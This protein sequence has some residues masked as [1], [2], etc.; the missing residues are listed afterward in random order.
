M[1]DDIPIVIWVQTYPYC[2]PREIEA[3]LQRWLQIHFA[4]EG[5]RPLHSFTGRMIRMGFVDIRI[6]NRLDRIIFMATS[7]T[8]FN[9]SLLAASTGT[10]IYYLSGYDHNFIYGY[11]FYT[12]Y[13][14]LVLRLQHRRLHASSSILP[15]LRCETRAPCI[16]NRFDLDDANRQHLPASAL[17]LGTASIIRTF[18]DVDSITVSSGYQWRIMGRGG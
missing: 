12:I 10:S 5:P 14:W 15:P 13:G 8:Q 4:F 7:D 17:F 11:H 3:R 2:E 18:F 1:S 16:I 9:N 6:K